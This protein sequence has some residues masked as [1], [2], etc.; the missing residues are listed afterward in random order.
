MQ[1]FRQS[2]EDPFGEEPLNG[3]LDPFSD[4]P[5]DAMSNALE[6]NMTSG[7]YPLDPSTQ[8]SLMED[9]MDDLLTQLEGSIE[10]SSPIPLEPGIP[11]MHTESHDSSDDRFSLPQAGSRYVPLLPYYIE[12]SQQ[13]TPPCKPHR[14][15]GRIGRRGG[16]SGGTR[17]GQGDE[18]YCPV[19]KRVVT[20]DFC[21]DRD[22][23]YYD[24]DSDQGNGRYCTYHDEENS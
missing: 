24:E 11:D 1:G 5:F 3:P 7:A 10:N 17:P 13:A 14:P 20:S 12:K 15:A 22:C 18:T 9:R 19:E 16:S 2:S 4:D 8:R 6:Q 23:E 21:K